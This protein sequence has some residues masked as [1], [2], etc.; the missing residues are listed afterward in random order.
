M[1]ASILSR[2]VGRRAFAFAGRHSLHGLGIEVLVLLVRVRRRVV[3][4]RSL[5][6]G[7]V[8]APVG[9]GGLWEAIAL[10]RV[11]GFRMGVMVL[12]VMV[13]LILVLLILLLLKL[14]HLP[15]VLQ[16]DQP[17]FPFLLSH[18]I[19]VEHLLFRRF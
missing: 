18:R 1:V 10:L 12:L 19:Q 4:V 6:I 5:L 2:G 11:W 13:L 17:S 9:G 7:E 16:I 14:H 3:L 8:V 15:L